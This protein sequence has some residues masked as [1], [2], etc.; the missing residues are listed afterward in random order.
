M[1]QVHL[2][3]YIAA[4]VF[5]NFMFGFNWKYVFL[6]DTHHSLEQMLKNFGHFKR[7]HLVFGKIFKLLWFILYDIGQIFIALNSQKL[8]NNLS[9]WS[10]WTQTEDLCCQGRVVD[11]LFHNHR[12]HFCVK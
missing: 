10:H 11:Q 5:F 4:Q 8:S 9:I 12:G 7:V 1:E 3:N 6:Q 2:P